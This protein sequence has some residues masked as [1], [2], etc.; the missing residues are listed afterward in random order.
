M[1]GNAELMRAVESLRGDIRDLSAKLDTT[2]VRKDVYA[3]D[4]S[5]DALQM[6][7]I[8]D[9]VHIVSKRIDKTEE[10]QTATWRLALA[11]LIYP[12]IVG[13]ILYLIIGS[14]HR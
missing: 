5:A 6:Q 3:A 11:G 8:E 9:S 7:S 14:V 10:R 2:A 1:P 12:L 4:R 13:I